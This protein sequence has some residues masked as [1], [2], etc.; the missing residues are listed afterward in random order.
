MKK[1]LRAQCIKRRIRS[2]VSLLLI[3]TF[4]H[5]PALNFNVSAT[6]VIDGVKEAQYTD[7]HTVNVTDLY[8]NPGGVLQ[9]TNNSN[10]SGKVSYSWDDT[11]FYFYITATPNAT[12][13]PFS[14]FIKH[15]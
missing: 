1:C 11:Y 12:R 4:V 7:R 8:S 10:V 6:T 2:L 3:V 13:F 15:E 14:S 9:P 5:P